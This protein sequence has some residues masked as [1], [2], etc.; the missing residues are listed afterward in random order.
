MYLLCYDQPNS[1]IYNLD[2]LKK[3]IIYKR[4]KFDTL[5]QLSWYHTKK[6]I[7]LNFRYFTFIINGNWVLVIAIV[8]EGSLYNLNVLFY[9]VI[10]NQPQ[11]LSVIKSE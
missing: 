11:V 1:S 2:T 10:S 9:N 8:F 5:T 6:F 3:P 4:K 7:F